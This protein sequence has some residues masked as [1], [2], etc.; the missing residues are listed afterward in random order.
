MS[1][2]LRV[3][4]MQGVPGSGK[5]TRVNKLRGNLRAKGIHSDV[6]SA[7]QF[8]YRTVEGKE[9]YDFCVEDL[10]QAH[11]WCFRRFLYSL[12]TMFPGNVLFV[13]NTNI[14]PIE[15]APYYLGAQ[16]IGDADVGILRVSAKLDDCLAR[17]VHNV[18]EHIVHDMYCRLHTNTY[19]KWWRFISSKDTDWNDVITL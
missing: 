5:S 8:F 14:E 18:P 19:P 15:I 12:K 4:I 6:V 13:D 7:D 17:G 9:I 16:S 10:G 1:E 3:V 11:Q 2:K